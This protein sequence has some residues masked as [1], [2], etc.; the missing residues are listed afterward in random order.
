MT[1][2][3]VDRLIDQYLT[4]L[5]DAAHVLPEDRRD[6]LVTEIREHIAAS[7]AGQ[8]GADEATVRTML[9]RLGEPSD[10]VEAALDDGPSGHPA[11]QVANQ[12]GKRGIGLEIGA[13]VML[14]AGS[15][16][17]VIGWLV[18]VVLLWSSGVWRR[19]E[20]ILGTLVFPGGPGVAL[21]LVSLPTQSCSETTVSGG[22]VST[23]AAVCTGIAVSPWL[24]IPILL[25]A[26]IG[27][28]VVPIL[29]LK[30][31]RSRTALENH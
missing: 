24:G 5:A 20:K 9:D 15:L 16:I 27:S 17:P 4:R 3:K 25:L 10:I 30:R 19:S 22:Q 18:G 13:V 31:A 12:A 29:L 2:S 1:N 6:E 23:S 8:A 11:Y 21:L 7:G 26:L 14:T 28:V